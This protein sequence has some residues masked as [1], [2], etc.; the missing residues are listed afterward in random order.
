MVGTDYICHTCWELITQNVDELPISQ[1]HRNVCVSCGRSVLRAR[2]RTIL[3]PEMSE[4]ELRVQYI[5]TQWILPREVSKY[6]FGLLKI[7]TKI[8]KQLLK[9]SIKSF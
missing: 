7:K 8:I 9:Y 6:I 1:G 4:R 3:R 5:I 2:S